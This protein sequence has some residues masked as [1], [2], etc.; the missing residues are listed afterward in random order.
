MKLSVDRGQ[1][2]AQLSEQFH[3]R[4]RPTSDL[5]NHATRR[6]LEH[7]RV[8]EGRGEKLLRGPQEAAFSEDVSGMIEMDDHLIA[9]RRRIGE[10][11][12]TLGHEEQVPSRLPRFE[13][14]AARTDGSHRP[15]EEGP[16]SCRPVWQCGRCH[17]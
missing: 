17:S 9:G 6:H 14:P 15:R 5:V 12:E 3:Q 16:K 1:A 2:A 10:L 4:V 11:H 13:D 7:V 8:F